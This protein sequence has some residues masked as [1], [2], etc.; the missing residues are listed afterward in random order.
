MNELSQLLI[1]I[2]EFGCLFGCLFNWNKEQRCDYT[3]E[4]EIETWADHVASAIGRVP[5]GS[6][7]AGDR[8]ITFNQRW[9][10]DWSY[11]RDV[12]SRITVVQSARA[13]AHIRNLFTM[14][15]AESRISGIT[16]HLFVAPRLR[17]AVAIRVERKAVRILK[18][19]NRAD[20]S[21]VTL[22]PLENI[23]V[24][25]AGSYL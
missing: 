4:G 8:N 10:P 5:S 7:A 17:S 2:Q 18:A 19:L 16:H 11:F 3:F 22:I 21:D 14:R 20:E 12:K 9:R 1:Y 23:A 13:V 24:F 15:E 6:R 25:A